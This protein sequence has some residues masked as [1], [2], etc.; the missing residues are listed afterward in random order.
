MAASGFVGVAFEERAGQ[1]KIFGRNGAAGVGFFRKRKRL[2]GNLCGR[3]FVVGSRN[4]R[5]RSGG[6]DLGFLAATIKNVQY[7]LNLGDT[8]VVVAEDGQWA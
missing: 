6:G 4:H 5:T 2:G 8:L 1:R 7:I 3:G